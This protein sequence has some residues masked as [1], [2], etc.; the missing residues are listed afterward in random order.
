MK[1]ITLLLAA[2]AVTLSVSAQRSKV[3][4]N[5]LERE[6]RV[7]SSNLLSSSNALRSTNGTVTDT[8]YPA[9]VFTVCGR[10]DSLTVYSL[11]G[12]GYLTGN[13]KY[14]DLQKGMLVKHTGTG[15]VTGVIA[16]I[17]PKKATG[18]GSASMKIYSVGTDK[19]PATLLGTSTSIATSTMTK[20][21]QTFVF[22]TPVTV[23]GNFFA[24]LALPT[25]TND[26]IALFS[27]KQTCVLTDS[28]SME[29][30]S[31]NSFMYLKTD[32]SVNFDLA[33]YPI[34]Q[35]T[36]TGVAENNASSKVSVFPNPANDVL[37]VNN[38][39]KDAKVVMVNSLG[40]VVYN[41]TA[42]EK[43]TINT[44]DMKEGFYFVKINENVF[45][46]VITK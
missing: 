35:T 7:T 39:G 17:Y 9:S 45:K 18:G 16:L 19:M 10:L 28:L 14:G 34:V 42:S 46:V 40:Q 31:D 43:L 26:T 27:T 13:N 15:N 37:N 38:I 20:E 30:F 36:T 33:I 6:V 25:T 23:T 21:L 11:K 29:Q 8:I 3:N 24:E 5:S 41:T 12:G 2:F 44:S 22:T 4:T 1:K 32:W